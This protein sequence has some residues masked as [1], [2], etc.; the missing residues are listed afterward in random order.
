MSSNDSRSADQIERDI[1]D[2]RTRL[3]ATVDELAYRAKPKTIANRQLE[4]AKRGL[5]DVTTTPRGDLRVEIIAPVAIAVVGLVAV[6]LINR[7]R[8]G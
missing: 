4:S 7:A 8:R 2:A 1:V 3:A 5:R 6:A